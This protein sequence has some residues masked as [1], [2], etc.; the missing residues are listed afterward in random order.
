M[1]A[2]KIK[3]DIILKNK[4]SKKDAESL[5]KDIE[6][7]KN[8]TGDIELDKYWGDLLIMLEKVEEAKEKY[9]NFKNNSRNGLLL[10]DIK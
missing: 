8:I 7:Y 10:L 1:S 3:L 5:I 2:Y 6:N 9:N 4:L